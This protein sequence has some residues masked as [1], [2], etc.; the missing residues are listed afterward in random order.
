MSTVRAKFDGAKWRS[1]ILLPLW[2]L[3]LMFATSTA[4]LFAWRLTDVAQ[5]HGEERRRRDGEASD[6]ELAWQIINIIFASATSVCTFF[7]MARF[8]GEVLTPRAMVMTHIFKLASGIIILALDVAVYVVRKDAR[9]SLVGLGLDLAQIA[10]VMLLGFYA[11]LTYRRTRTYDE[12]SR[13]LNAKSYGFNDEFP[14]T[15]ASPYK[16]NRFSAPPSYTTRTQPTG[17]YEIDSSSPSSYSHRRST[18]FDEYVARRSSQRLLP[19]SM[20]M[21]EVEQ[22]EIPPPAATTKLLSRGDAPRLSGDAGGLEAVAEEESGR[23]E[24]RRDAC[25]DGEALLWRRRSGSE[26]CY[27]RGSMLAGSVTGVGLAV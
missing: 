24:A 17:P 14:S 18:Q 1:N 21:A 11:G 8:V 19:P 6:L 23:K 15:M 27:S 25:C 26:S 20:L 22:L 7:E 13:P 16:I 2:A 3:Q 5:R 4:G 12:Y 10:C 9:Y